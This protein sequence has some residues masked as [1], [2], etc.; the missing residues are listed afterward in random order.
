MLSSTLV[1]A[2]LDRVRSVDLESSLLHRILGLKKVQIGTGVDDDR[3]TLTRCR[4]RPG[5]DRL[6]VELL[7]RAP[8][9]RT[10]RRQPDGRPARGDPADRPVA[11]LLHRR[12]PR[13]WPGSTGPGCGSRRSASAR[14]VV[15][16]AAFGA[17]SQFFDNLPLD[18]VRRRLA[19]ARFAGARRCWWAAS[20]SPSSAG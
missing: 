4:R 13:S 18:R 17:L 9:G 11:A 16:A 19:V 10:R 20:P 12:P 8:R 5:A 15:V 6:R 1:T 7:Q 3:I 2:P 14:L